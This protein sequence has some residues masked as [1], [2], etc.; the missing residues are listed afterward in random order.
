MQG[1]RLRPSRVG[2]SA[3]NNVPHHPEDQR[4]PH[5][6][7]VRVEANPPRRKRLGFP[8]PRP[9]RG[10]RKAFGD[11]LV[12]KAEEIVAEARRIPA[13]QGYAPHLVFRVPLADGAPVD[14]VADKIR[15]AG[16]TVVSIEPD[17]AVIVF[18]DDANL[19]DFR[20]ALDEYITGPR[21]IAATG[22]QAKSTQWDI[23]EFIEDDQMRSWS[24]Q[25]RIG[26]RLRDEIGGDAARINAAGIYVLDIELWHPGSVPQARQKMAELEALMAQGRVAGERFSD[27]FVGDVLAVARVSASGTRLSRLLDASIIAEIDLPEQPTFDA[28]AAAQVTAREFPPPPAPAEDGPRVCSIDSG[29]VSNHPLLAA[30]VGHREAVLTATDE[31]ADTNGHGTHVAGLAVFGD[32]RACYANG[33]FSSPVQ[34]FSARV[35]NDQNRFDD[36]RLIHTQMEVA[37]ELFRNPPHNCRVFN[38]SLGS[39]AAVL[40]GAN[41]RQTLWAESLDIL[42]RKHKVLIVVSAGNNSRVHADRPADAEA[43]LANYPRYLFEPDCGLCDPATAAIPLTVGS[44]AQFA[45]PAIRRGAG[46]GDFVRA[47]AGVDEPSPFTRVGFSISGAIKPELVYYGGNLLFEGVGNQFRRVRTENPDAGVAVMSFSNQPLDSLFS[48]SVGTSQAAPPVARM[49]AVVWKGL[50]HAIDGDLDPNL[51][52]AVLANSA[53]VPHAAARRIEPIEGE[54]GVLRACGYG[55]PDAELALQSGDRRVTLIAQGRIEIDTLLLFEVPVPEVFRNAPGKKKIIASLAFDPPVRR[56]R[57]EYLGVEMGMNLFR[58]KTPD[59]IVAAY[60][61]IRREERADAPAALQSPH[62]CGL[63]PNSRAIETSTLQRREWAFSRTND[64]YGDT[65]F[66]MVQ[67]RRN[68]AP[69]EIHEQDFGIA[70]TIAANEPRLYNQV[71]HRLRT[72]ERIRRRA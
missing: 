34:L 30:N 64:A 28:V 65:Y 56:R 2:S 57:A 12:A 51:V 40:M 61:S 39:P 42:A 27:Q 63:L 10:E 54:Q 14:A 37:I 60:R 15:D 70:V 5:L 41:L 68:W 59:E 31:P 55:L 47:V 21:I 22:K 71:Q 23:F 53:S 35:L 7:L 50:E 1:L 38:L 3:L 46:A 17:Q 20:R 48:F 9:N 11:A 44:I 58:G 43:V 8:G 33:N 62:K 66:L 25:D 49:S 52:R 69:A 24:R 4:Y 6:P 36:D 29:V 72:R 26:R 13:V 18:Q 16:L 32:I 67:A 45:A 19:A